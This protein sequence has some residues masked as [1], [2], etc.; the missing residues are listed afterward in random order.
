[1]FRSSNNKR[2]L[3]LLSALTACLLWLA[4]V[5]SVRAAA[6]TYN[7]RQRTINAGV[8]FVGSASDLAFPS[9]AANSPAPVP[10][11]APYVFY[12]LDQRPDVKPVGWR[13]VNP[14][15]Q[16]TVSTAMSNRWAGTTGAYNGA[17]LPG[18]GLNPGMASYWEVALRDVSADDLQQFDVLYLAGSY[19]VGT[20]SVPVAGTLTPADNEKLRRFV[21]G[22]GQLIVDYGVATGA[23]PQLFGAFTLFDGTGWAS[24]PAASSLTAP[25]VSGLLD[26]HPLLTQPNYFQP[27]DLLSLGAPS[28]DGSFGTITEPASGSLFSPVLLQGGGHGVDAAQL[29]AG[30]VVS[31]ALNLGPTISIS[32]G[33]FFSPPPP[34][35]GIYFRQAPYYS[36]VHSYSP[37]VVP[38]SDL[39]LLSNAISWEDTHPTEN[40]TSHQ[41]AAGPS[42][43]SF[44][45]A[46]SY[47]VPN[48]SSTTLPPPGAAVHGDFVYVTDSAGILHAFDAIPSEG[49]TGGGSDDGIADFGSTAAPTPYDEIWNANVGAN[50]SGPTVATVGGLTYVFVETANGS[51]LQFSDINTAANTAPVKTYA[52][53]GT[54]TFSPNNTLTTPHAPAPTFYDGR[55]Y[56][57]EPDGT[58]FVVGLNGGS[59]GGNGVAIPVDPTGG[60][61]GSSSFATASPAVG[62]LGS[63][64]GLQQHHRPGADHSE[65]EFGSAGRAQR[66]PQFVLAERAVHGLQCQPA[67][68]VQPLQPVY[69]HILAGA[70][71]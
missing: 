16:S 39:K 11:P 31:S 64:P 23:Q 13:F 48:S 44:T 15:A 20:N 59:A 41:N 1:M 30:Q 12:V 71:L 61:A 37:S 32:Q 3:L 4:P 8:L 36:G 70:G 65:H 58:M 10:D 28:P 42:S 2:C 55:I 7:A 54:A 18:A 67:R 62:I 40:K 43:A 24:G 9:A 14:L 68:P 53:P 19:V 47:P 6:Y 45:A 69:R 29:G 25:T 49:L 60:G 22:G 33:P 46:W 5:R 21:D 57:G 66:P 52:A 27:N 38:A 56:A 34:T 51:V 35:V 26:L 50:A 17:Y 63:G